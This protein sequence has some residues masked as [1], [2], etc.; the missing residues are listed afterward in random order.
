MKK[1]YTKIAIIL[2]RSGSMDITKSA[3]IEGFNSFI[4]S[5]RKDNVE[6]NVSLYQFDDQ[7]E[8]VYENKDVR[9]APL[10]TNT[11]FVPRGWTALLDAIGNTINRLGDELSSTKE[12]ARPEKVI[13]AIITDGAEN[14]SKVFSRNQVFNMI[15]HQSEKYNWKFMFLAANQDAIATAG[16]YGIAAASSLTYGQTNSGTKMAFTS[17]SN[18]IS[19]YKMNR[20]FTPNFS[21]NDR[22][23]QN[24]EIN[25]TLNTS[26]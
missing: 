24:K 11:S 13:V 20:S 19:D 21:V 25:Q 17:M 1:D 22:E 4:E 6:C 12:S 15:K 10:L 3:T 9:N 5:Q 26:K 16:S 18:S 2:D 8:V 23:E 14:K 7:Y